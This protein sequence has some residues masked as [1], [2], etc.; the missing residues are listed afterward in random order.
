MKAELL[1]LGGLCL[2][3]SGC[4]AT[5]HEER[6]FGGPHTIVASRTETIEDRPADGASGG[7]CRQVT[8]TYPIVRDVTV[9]RSFADDAQTRNVAV[10]TLLGAG[11]AFLAYGTNQSACS[12]ATGDCPD[13]P[14][15]KTTEAVLAALAAIPIG[16]IVYNA[17]RVQ[18]TRTFE[19]V[20][21]TWKRP[22][23]SDEVPTKGQTTA[24]Q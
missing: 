18:D 15:V 21:P 6:L 22:P 24:S 1:L 12:A 17:I 11:I 8:L 4:V 2:G 20:T 7:A 19:Y 13:F 10:A 16:F 5:L 14:L 3:G 9:R 23:C